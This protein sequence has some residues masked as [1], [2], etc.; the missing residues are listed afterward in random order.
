[1]ALDGYHLNSANY[2]IDDN[3]DNRFCSR[4]KSSRL[5][6]GVFEVESDT[7][8]DDDMDYGSIS[9]RILDTLYCQ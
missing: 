3:N 4:S 8:T 2:N 6:P 1:M 9:R 7:C 5:F